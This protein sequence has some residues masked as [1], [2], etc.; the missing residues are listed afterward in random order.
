[1][2][3]VIPFGFTSL[4]TYFQSGFF[5][6]CFGAGDQTQCLYMLGKYSTTE[7][8]IFK[9]LNSLFTFSRFYLHDDSK[10]NY[11]HYMAVRIKYE[12]Y[13]HARMRLLCVTVYYCLTYIVF[14]RDVFGLG[15]NGGHL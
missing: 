5:F 13:D 8:L 9:F 3:C 11:F 6:V 15:C 10:C 12:M 7:L 4:S 2:V 14:F 1:M